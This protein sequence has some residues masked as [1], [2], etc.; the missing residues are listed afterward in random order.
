[1]KL[2]EFMAAL[3]RLDNKERGR[4]DALLMVLTP[5]SKKDLQEFQARWDF[6]RPFKEYVEA[7][8]EMIER[9]VLMEKSVIG[10]DVRK[11]L[12]MEPLT[13]ETEVPEGDFTADRL[14]FS[15]N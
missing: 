2:K 10:A 9:C 11:A 6:S 4:I 1:M 15:R 12:S 5:L 13:S 3:P 14:G 7:Q 8:N